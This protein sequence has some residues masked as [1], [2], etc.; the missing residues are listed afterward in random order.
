MVLGTFVNKEISQYFY[1][2]TLP[3]VSGSH[4]KKQ[5]FLQSFS[6]ER[7]F[8][9]DQELCSWPHFEIEIVS[10]MIH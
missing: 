3:L 9:Q 2:W 6:C 1:I 5:D 8:Y 7:E 10:S 4:F